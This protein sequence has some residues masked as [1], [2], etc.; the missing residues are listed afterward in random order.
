VIRTQRKCLLTSS[1]LGKDASSEGASQLKSSESSELLSSKRKSESFVSFFRRSFK[2]GLY[3]VG[4]SG[5]E[6]EESGEAR[7]RASSLGLADGVFEVGSSALAA[8][9]DTKVIG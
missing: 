2:I 7:P 5:P 8:R 9:F 1:F 6:R 4:E 3:Q